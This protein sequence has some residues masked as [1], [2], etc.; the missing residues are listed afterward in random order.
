MNG[1]QK[2][3]GNLLIIQRSESL[4]QKVFLLTGDSF[5]PRRYEITLQVFSF[6]KQMGHAFTLELH[7]PRLLQERL[8]AYGEKLGLGGSIKMLEYPPESPESY[9]EIVSITEMFGQSVVLRKSG[10]IINRTA[11]PLIESLKYSFEEKDG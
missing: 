8:K 10:R 5:V 4:P 11:V 9:E 7:V 3:A 6:F 1:I 2:K